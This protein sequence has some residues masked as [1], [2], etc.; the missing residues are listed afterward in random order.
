MHSKAGCENYNS[1][2]LSGYNSLAEDPRGNTHLHIHHHCVNDCH[3]LRWA[4]WGRVWAAEPGRQCAELG[5]K[6]TPYSHYHKAGFRARVR[7]MP[8][9]SNRACYLVTNHAETLEIY[10]DSHK[11][12]LHEPCLLRT[13]NV[14]NSETFWK[15]V[16]PT[17]RFI[18]KQEHFLL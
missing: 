7:Y 5:T 1:L 15:T 2:P 16:V 4:V 9:N 6:Q 10:T 13:V 14:F 17:A 12:T 8:H 3:R 18:L 11:R